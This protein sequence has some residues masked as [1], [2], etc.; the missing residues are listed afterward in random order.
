MNRQVDEDQAN[1]NLGKYFLSAVI[2][3]CYLTSKEARVILEN[4]EN[5]TKIIK[6]GHS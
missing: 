3:L 6:K 5:L 1:S 4:S 2:K